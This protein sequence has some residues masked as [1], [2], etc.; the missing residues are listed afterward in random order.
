MSNEILFTSS[1]RGTQPSRSPSGGAFPTATTAEGLLAC[2]SASA[3]SSSHVTWVG[4]GK[5]LQAKK[6]YAYPIKLCT[7]Q[8]T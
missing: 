2:L 1:V 6:N 8:F 5:S 3:S 4:L 7:E